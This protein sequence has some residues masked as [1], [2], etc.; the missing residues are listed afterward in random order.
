MIQDERK[1]FA[2]RFLHACAAGKARAEAAAM[3]APGFVHHNAHFAGDGASLFAAMDANATQFP[4]KKIAVHHALADGDLVALHSHVKHTA[5]D[6]GFALLHLFRFEGAAI[7]ELWDIAEAV[8]PDS[9]NA[10]GMF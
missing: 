10:N 1:A 6:P 9:P 8:P 4:D 5:E 2:T 7:A 3:V